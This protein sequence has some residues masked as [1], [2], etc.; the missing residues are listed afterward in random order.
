MR[1]SLHAS[2]VAVGLGWAGATQGAEIPEMTEAMLN[3]ASRIEVGETIW[4]EQCTHCHGRDAY[5]GKAPK[6]KPQRYSPDFVYH[7]VTFGFRGM[8]A[9]EE[10][11]TQDERIDLVAYILSGKFSP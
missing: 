4:N 10:I 7:R 11:Y 2:I 1:R 6:L 9:W 3:D 5:P 8:P